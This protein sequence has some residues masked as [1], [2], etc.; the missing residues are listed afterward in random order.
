M[1]IYI[2]GFNEDIIM[3]LMDTGEFNDGSHDWFNGFIGYL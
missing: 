2:I 3:D 1:K